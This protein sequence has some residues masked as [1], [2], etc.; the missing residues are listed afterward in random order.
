MTGVQTCALPIWSTLGE[1]SLVGTNATVVPQ[2]HVGK[3]VRIG[4]GSI[5]VRDVPDGWHVFGNPA[6]RLLVPSLK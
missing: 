2:I 3:N 4:A 6:S 5:V 1:D